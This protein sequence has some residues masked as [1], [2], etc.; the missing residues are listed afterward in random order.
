MKKNN[1]NNLGFSHVILMFLVV[2]VLGFISFT[3]YRLVSKSQAGSEQTRSISAPANVKAVGLSYTSVALRWDVSRSNS[4]ATYE[5]LRDGNVIGK[6]ANYV[7]SFTDKNVNPSTTYNYT[8]LAMVGGRTSISNQPIK[9]TTESSPETKDSRVKYITS[10][11]SPDLPGGGKSSKDNLITSNSLSQN[12]YGGL[13]KAPQSAPTTLASDGYY[14]LKNDINTSNPYICM[15]LTQLS[16]ITIDCQ[17]HSINAQAEYAYLLNIEN[18][19]NFKIV[20]CNIVDKFVANIDYIAYKTYIVSSNN[21]LFD[22]DNFGSSATRD[23]IVNIDGGESLGFTNS[24]F[25]N[26]VLWLNST[27]NFLV[28]NNNITWTDRKI[29]NSLIGS[30]DGTNNIYVGNTLNNTAVGYRAGSDD[31]IDIGAYYVPSYQATTTFNTNPPVEKQSVVYGNTIS[32]VWDADIE[33]V[34]ILVG[35]NI[36]N[37]TL[38]N[39]VLAGVSSYWYTQWINNNIGGNRFVY[40]TSSEITGPGYLDIGGTPI[41]LYN[42]NTQFLDANNKPLIYQFTNNVFYANNVDLS[43]IPQSEISKADYINFNINMSFQK[44][45]YTSGTFHAYEGGRSL[46]YT[47]DNSNVSNNTLVDNNFG[48]IKNYGLN[49]TG[50]LTNPSLNPT[51]GFIDGGRNTCSKYIPIPPP[52]NS[53]VGGGRGGAAARSKAVNTKIDPTLGKIS[54]SELTIGQTDSAVYQKLKTSLS[55]NGADSSYSPDYTYL[56]VLK[57]TN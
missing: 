5:V 40:G 30:Y 55:G 39:P 36:S 14:I 1:L 9:V 49:T 46:Y 33:G 41:T 16:N 22:N 42:T 52:T 8:V 19:N 12:K 21:G 10:C 48:V 37:N 51:S 53:G 26:N 27:K 15:D 23:G 13:L 28:A 57:C 34:G 56:N 2:F 3:F 18:T 4:N 50:G 45:D 7:T 24:K 35:N 32:G 11:M 47:K 29:I 38:I 17:G 54:G 20:N 43:A 25:T 31:G 6:T 44:D